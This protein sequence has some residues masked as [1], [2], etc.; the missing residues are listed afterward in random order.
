M[1][2]PVSGV[3]GIDEVPGNPLASTGARMDLLKV[4]PFEY[5]VSG[6]DDGD[7]GTIGLG[8]WLPDNARVIAC[9]VDVI[10]T[11]TSAGDTATIALKVEGANDLVS[12]LAINDGDDPWDAGGG[13]IPVP[14]LQD[15][16]TQPKTTQARQVS[17]V[18]ATQDLTA[19]KLQGYLLYFVS[20]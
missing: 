18:V 2:G 14:D 6:G 5:D 20:E 15:M 4:L 17:A 8:K 13:T 16:S 7:Q 1:G 11:F 3:P 12:A 19:G 9:I 10:T